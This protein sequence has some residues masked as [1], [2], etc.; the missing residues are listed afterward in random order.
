MIK[1]L[2]LKKQYN[3]IKNEIDNAIFKVIEDSAFVGGKYTQEFEQNFAKY[4][5]IKH[6]LGVG[7]GT[8][9]LEIAL[10]ALNL[11]KNSEVLIPANTFIATAESV[12]RNNLRVKFVDCNKYYQI[13]TKSVEENITKN[14][15]AIIAVHLY[16]HPANMKKIQEIAK[17]H[18]LKVIED[19]AQAHGAELDGIKVGNFSDVATF[20]FYP[21]KN[22]GAYGD[23]GCIVT[24]NEDLAKKIRMY[25]NHGR[26]EKYLHEFEGRN[27]RLDGIQAAVLNVKLKYLDNWIEKR[28][29]IAKRYLNEIKNPKIKLP[30]VINNIKHAWHLFVI[31]VENRKE[32][33]NYMKKNNIQTGIHYPIA[34]PKLKAYKYLNFD[35]TN[36]KACKENKYLVSIPIGEH[37]E[38]EEVDFIIET[39]NKY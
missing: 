18:N 36:Y 5:G 21:G 16:G 30:K 6:A 3:T 29:Q 33:I 32:F 9:A 13:N 12:T 22:L 2:D 4:I 20:S 34:L 27:S 14:T 1:F 24:N 15:S 23:G 8:D 26:S 25:S 11:P 38:K 28:N 10:W 39:I 7:N 31:Q 19:C 37:L 35:C 17:K